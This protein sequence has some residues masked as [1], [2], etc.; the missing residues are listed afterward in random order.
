MNPKWI[1]V[2]EHQRLSIGEPVEGGFFE[3]R[4]WR[5]LRLFLEVSRY[6]YFQVLPGGIQFQQYV[7]ALQTDDLTIEIVPKTDRHSKG[8]ADR[9]Q[10]VLMDMLE[11]CRLWRGEWI[12]GARLRVKSGY[13]LSWYCRYFLAQVEFLLRYGLLKSYGRRQSKETSLKGR[14]LLQKQILEKQAHFWTDRQLFDYAHP[15]N[16]WIKAA[17]EVIQTH[18]PDE[19]LQFQASRLSK[20]FPPLSQGLPLPPL[21][22]A[23]RNRHYESVLVIAQLLLRHFTPVARRG[24]WPLMAVLFDMNLLFE[25]YIARQLEQ[26]CPPGGKVRRQIS[27]PFWNRR[28]IRPDLVLDYAGKRLVLDTK[29]KILSGKQ[30]AMDDVRQIYVY[31]DYFGADQ[32][33]LLYPRAGNFEERSAVPFAPAV[34]NNR[35][36][37]CRVLWAPVVDEQGK[38][39]RELGKKLW[40]KLMG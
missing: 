24:A 35:R 23:V 19:S 8:D 26:H 27:V 6:P 7:G 36:H 16:L 34:G 9:W 20:R 12:A 37:A 21:P 10:Q 31:N 39:D 5:K 14:L 17:L 38:L 4:H 1:R 2:F 32:G 28:Y 18:F 29:W 40:E 13:I 3:E 30:P 25:E 33:V 11:A 15:Y 22:Q